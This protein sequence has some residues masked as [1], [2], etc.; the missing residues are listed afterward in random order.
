MT[1]VKAPAG[2]PQVSDF[3]IVRSKLFDTGTELPDNHILVQAQF[4]SVDPYLRSRLPSWVGRTIF[5]NQ[6]CKIIN[7][8]KQGA[9]INKYKIGD[10]LV[11]TLPCCD[12]QLINLSNKKKTAMLQKLLPIPKNDA[13]ITESAYLGMLGLT[14][15]TAYQGLFDLEMGTL[16]KNEN[17]FVSGAAGAVGSAVG[18]IAK[19]VLNCNVVGIAGT[20]DK[21]DYLIN[22]L[23]FDDGIC[24]RD[25]VFGGNKRDN[26]FTSLEEKI[27][28][29]NARIEA[30]QKILR[31]KFPKGIDFYFDNVGGWIT[32]AVWDLLNRNARVA[33]C[34]QIYLYNKFDKNGTLMANVQ[35]NMLELPLINDFLYKTIYKN[36]KIQGF[37]L[38]DFK[39]WPKFY[40]DMFGWIK[41]GKI[42]NREHVYYGF[43][44]IPNAF[45]GLFKGEN[46]G[47]MVIDVRNDR[48]T[49]SKL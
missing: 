3:S 31:K 7:I 13:N 16:K 2:A 46:T 33:I 11:G 5:T 45:L 1:L 25:S 4:I 36:V 43:E 38:N 47:K 17:V 44:N 40:N 32:A 42:Q 35:N 41:Q 34:G 8:S 21:I 49:R 6:I 19:N 10:L 30:L 14:G 9:N 28:F 48:S 27:R 20:Q 37:V 22:D 18:Q 24:Y 39:K 12:Y 26:D 15:A 23:G 29:D